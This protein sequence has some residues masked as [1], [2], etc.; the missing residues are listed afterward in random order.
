[1]PKSSADNQRIVQP[2]PDGRWE[3]VK[4]HHQRASVV[5]DTQRQAID[6][7]RRIVRN[8]GGGELRVKGRD[9]RLRDSDTITPGRESARRDTK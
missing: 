4:P 7:A 3:V 6:A 2:R 9:G 1:M 8:A 5:T